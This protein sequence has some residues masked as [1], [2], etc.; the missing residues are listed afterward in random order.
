[1]GDS[2]TIGQISKAAG[3]PTS[4][5][6]YYERTGLLRPS[7][8]SPSNYRIYSASD[9]ERLRFIRAAQ[10]TGFTLDDVS[11]L[12]RPAPCS[13]VQGLIER[14]LEQIAE[15]MRELRHV[16]KVLRGSLSELTLFPDSGHPGYAA[17]VPSA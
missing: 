14:R 10:A 16:Q 7:T 12:L 17:H 8:R 9:L 1:M 13:K 4:T 15:R 11:R 6:R 3:V 5:V 2:L